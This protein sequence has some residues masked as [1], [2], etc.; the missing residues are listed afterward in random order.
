[1]VGIEAALESLVI[2]SQIDQFSQNRT[3]CARQD[4]I[5]L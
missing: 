5:E 4:S 3:G 2:D 1:M